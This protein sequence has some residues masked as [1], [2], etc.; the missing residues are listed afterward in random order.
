MT[1]H[2]SPEVPSLMVTFVNGFSIVLYSVLGMF[3]VTWVPLSGQNL[4]HLAAASF[5]ISWAYFLSVLVMRKGDVAYIAPFRYTGLIWALLTGLI[6]FGHGP[7]G[8]S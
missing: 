2:I 8:P 4:W 6:F 7:R 1:R 3:W 5:F